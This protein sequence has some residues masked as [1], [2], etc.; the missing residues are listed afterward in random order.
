MSAAW[1]PPQGL[2][3]NPGLT[4]C[5]CVN[6]YIFLFCSDVDAAVVNSDA[7]SVDPTSMTYKSELSPPGLPSESSVIHLNAQPAP[8][9]VPPHA[10]GT[11]SGNM[12]A[13]G[14]EMSLPA[15]STMTA[16]LMDTTMTQLNCD[17]NMTSQTDSGELM[18]P[19]LTLKDVAQMSQI[20]GADASHQTSEMNDAQT[21]GPCVGSATHGEID[22]ALTTQGVME[23]ALASAGLGS[24]GLGSTN[25][26]ADAEDDEDTEPLSKCVCVFGA[27][28]GSSTVDLV[29]KYTKYPKYIPSTSTGQVLIFLKST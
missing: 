2:S 14:L 17:T 5:I 8:P 16:P 3:T 25:L 1:P 9:S 18:T 15:Q 13:A 28:L 12:G 23:A 11:M 26:A 6:L 24:T 4:A 10:A 27:G 19:V 22:T 21:V 7:V 29:L 20:G